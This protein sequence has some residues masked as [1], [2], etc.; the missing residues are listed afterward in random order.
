MEFAK[1]Y[2]RGREAFDQLLVSGTLRAKA[3]RGAMF[4]SGGSIAEQASRFARNMLLTRLLA[5]GAF[6]AM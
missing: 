1:V 2:Q 6:G 4:L 5:P 3:T